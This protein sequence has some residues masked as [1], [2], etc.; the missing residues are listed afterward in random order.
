MDWH[1]NTIQGSSTGL[2]IFLGGFFM[3]GFAFVFWNIDN[4]FCDNLKLIRSSMTSYNFGGLTPLTQLHGW[5]HLCAG[6]ATHLH[7]QG[8]IY[9]RQV[10]LRDKIEFQ[11]TWMGIEAKRPLKKPKIT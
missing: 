5:W 1:L 6:Y 7:I 4:I 9:H 3:Y 8:C 11:I 10:F 2:R